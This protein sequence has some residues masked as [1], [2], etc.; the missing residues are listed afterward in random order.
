MNEQKIIALINYLISRIGAL[1][2]QINDLSGGGGGGGD[3]TSVFGRTGVITSQSGDYSKAQVGLGNVENTALS[4]WAGSANIAT[5]GTITSGTWNGTA[6]DDSHISSATTWNAKQDAFVSGTNIKTVN[7]TTLLG[8]GNLAVG[9]ALVANP[10]SQFAATTS[11]QLKNTI[12]D[13]TG[14]GSLVFAT[15]PSLVTPVLGVADSTSIS[16]S[17]TGGAGYV[18]LLNQ[19]SA[20]GTPT[21]SGRVYFDNSNRLSWIG[22]NGFTRTFDGTSNTASRIY[23]LPDAAGTVVLNDNSAALTNKTYNGNTWTAGTG[24]LTIAAGKTLT[25]SNSI[26]LAGTDSTVMTF[27]STSATI[28]RIDAAQTFTGNQT[29]NSN[30]SSFN[31]SAGASFRTTNGGSN[32]SPTVGIAMAGSQTVAG[33]I[34]VYWD[35]TTNFQNFV[36]ANGSRMISRAFIGLASLNNTAGSEAGDLIFGTQTGGTAAVEHFRILAAGGLDFPTTSTPAPASGHAVLWFDGTN[37]KMTKNVGG[38]TTTS[39]IF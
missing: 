7:S 20:P 16:V 11:L 33:S 9:D 18:Q 27:P 19:S 3:V 8:S 38:S 25:A 1:Q 4:I 13:E 17:G 12:S 34:G 5:V 21:S 29:F 39:T 35:A 14:S 31:L 36:A 26:S 6:I 24:I 32:I 10:L 15:S 22:T 28:A 2:K 23:T 30:I 37:I